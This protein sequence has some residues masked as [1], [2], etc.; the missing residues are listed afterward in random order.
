MVKSKMLL[1]MIFRDFYLR[2]LLDRGNLICYVTQTDLY[3]PFQSLLI[4]FF[5]SILSVMIFIHTTIII[6]LKY[7]SITYITLRLLIH[8]YIKY[9]APKFIL[10]CKVTFS[11]MMTVQ[12]SKDDTAMTMHIL[13]KHYCKGWQMKKNLFLFRIII[14]VLPS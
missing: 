14:S 2:V 7:L 12:R 3:V 13:C 6:V 9:I 1:S 11:D 5:A 4:Q 10:I 8:G